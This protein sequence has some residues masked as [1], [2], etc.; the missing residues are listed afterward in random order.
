MALENISRIHV[1]ADG[2]LVLP[3][4]ARTLLGTNNDVEL[5]LNE[6]QQG[7][8]LRRALHQP[9]KIYIEPTS[10]CN[11]S[12]RMCIRNAW[13]EKQGNMDDVTFQRLIDS[14][15][16]LP[17]KPAIVFGGFGEPL[18]H[19]KIRE[20]LRQAKEV[21]SRVELITNGIL[22]TEDLAQEFIR[23]K[24]DIIWFSLDRLHA[25]AYVTGA[26]P[27]AH[28]EKLNYLR[29]LENA[30][31]PETGIVFVA[32]RSNVHELPNLLRVASRY[33]ISHYMVTNVLPYTPEMCA[34]MLYTRSLDTR[35][36]QNSAWLPEVRLP[37]LDWDEST[38]M[39]LYQTF[40]T[41][42]NIQLNGVR[43]TPAK[44]RCPFIETGVVA[45]SWDG[46]VSPCLAL[47][48]SHVSYLYEKPRTV[49]RYVIG[50]L[51]NATLTELWNDADHLAFRQ[52]VHAFDF[53][54]CTLCGGCDMAEANQEDCFGNT[55]PTCGGCLWAWGVIQCP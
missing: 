3:P 30:H 23:L 24:L 37:R 40:R 6:V 39:P 7:V 1:D 5:L 55:F 31:L 17:E 16:A 8:V 21:A 54:P 41:Q 28:I 32:V 10:R 4:E 9:A 48:H 19:P 18:F 15:A 42:S 25:D 27:V 13:E 43:L 12:C 22:F 49:R 14:V 35:E 26:N 44:G 38:L 36:T 2:R 52:R 53:S 45:V 47:M 50:N 33:G 20:M 11:L 34:E 29:Y 46:A 51:N